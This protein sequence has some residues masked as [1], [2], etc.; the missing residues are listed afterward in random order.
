VVPVARD[1]RVHRVGHRHLDHG[2]LAVLDAGVDIETGEQPRGAALE[3]GLLGEFAQRILLRDA[4][5]EAAR[6]LPRPAAHRG[7]PLPDQHHALPGVRQH[8]HA[9]APAPDPDAVQLDARGGAGVVAVQE[10][11][12]EAAVR[13]GVHPA[14]RGARDR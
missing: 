10:D 11:L 1:G 9:A 7:P 13:V 14:A 2:H 5:P 12:D 8:H 4:L 6:Q 3:T